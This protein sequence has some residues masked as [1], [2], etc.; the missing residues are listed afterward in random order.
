MAGTKN[1]NY[2]H[3]LRGKKKII[4]RLVSSKKK[5]ASDM[6]CVKTEQNIYLPG[7]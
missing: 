3:L 2:T 5:M 6:I 1:L 7:S 4:Q